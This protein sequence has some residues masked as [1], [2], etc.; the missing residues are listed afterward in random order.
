MQDAMQRKVHATS[1]IASRFSEII[2]RSHS[3]LRVFDLVARVATSETSVLILGETGTGK[4]LIANAIHHASPRSRFPYIKVNCGALPDTLI[5]SELFGHEKGAFTG[6]LGKKIGRFEQAQGGTILLDEIA[7]MQPDL[8]VKLLRVLQEKEIERVGGTETIKMDVRI[9]AATNRNLEKEVAEGRFRLDLYYRLNVYPVTLPPLRERKEDIPL[10]ANF[11]AANFSKKAKRNFQSISTR[12]MTELQAY[13]WPGNIRELENVIERSVIMS[14]GNGI[15]ELERS[16]P[17]E[18]FSAT[19]LSSLKTLTDVKTLQLRTE[20]E[21]ILSVL[22]KTDGRIRG[23]GGAAELL[24]LK[25]TT[26]ESRLK[27]LGIQKEDY[28]SGNE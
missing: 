12:M 19:A 18:T 16:L 13:G 10:L 28:L 20:K 26:L 6:A 8:Q 23:E 14:D 3:L 5:E 9:I 25:P 1:G 11:F 22:K 24:D 27:K 17:A 7:E 4:E 15:L 21:Y 2:G